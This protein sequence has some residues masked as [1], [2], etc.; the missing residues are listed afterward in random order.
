[1]S[2]SR[3]S[4][5]PAEDHTEEEEGRGRWN[6]RVRSLFVRVITANVDWILDRDDIV[7]TIP[8][9]T[10]WLSCTSAV[11]APD[12]N[13]APASLRDE[14]DAKPR[15]GLPNP[16]SFALP[17]SR[18]LLFCVLRSPTSPSLSPPLPSDSSGYDAL[19]VYNQEPITFSSV[20][21]QRR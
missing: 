18:L 4:I 12:H 16:N 9:V 8:P 11:S 17:R 19:C 14:C 10:S 1:M 7:R 5:R 13:A 2:R 15:C 6:R 20:G 3:S 21:A